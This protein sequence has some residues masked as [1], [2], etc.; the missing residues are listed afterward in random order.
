MGKE[1]IVGLVAAMEL[2]LS[3]DRDTVHEVWNDRVR[4]LLRELQGIPGLRAEQRMAADGH[5]HGFL[6]AVVSW[7][8]KVIPINGKKLTEMLKGGEPRLV[9]YPEYGDEHSGVLQTRSMKEGEVMIAARRLRHVFLV[10][11]KAK[12]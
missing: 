12:A 1:E 2:Y 10:E 7:D 11:G 6:E 5:D 8:P 3:R 4:L 9:Y